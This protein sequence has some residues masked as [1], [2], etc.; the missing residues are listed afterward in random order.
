MLAVVYGCERLHTYIKR[1]MLAVVYGCERFHTYIYAK[2]VVVESYKHGFRCL[3]MRTTKV[4][5]W[6]GM[7][8]F[9]DTANATNNPIHHIYR[10]LSNPSV[11]KI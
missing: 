4:K 6:S 8:Q 3:A 11:K 10:K 2:H 9:M 5:Q 7:L 1:E